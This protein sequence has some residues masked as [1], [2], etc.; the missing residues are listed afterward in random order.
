MMD[1]CGRGLV[2]CR[3]YVNPSSLSPVRIQKDCMSIKMIYPPS[4]QTQA[5]CHGEK[6]LADPLV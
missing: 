1:A 4:M 3:H 5:V 2:A 6:N